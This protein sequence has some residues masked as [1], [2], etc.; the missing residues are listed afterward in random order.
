MIQLC[1]DHFFICVWPP[2]RWQRQGINPQ[3]TVSNV[4]NISCSMH[5]VMTRQLKVHN[6]VTTC[7]YVSRRYSNT[8]KSKGAHRMPL[9]TR[10][11]QGRWQMRNW[12]MTDNIAVYRAGK[13]ESTGRKVLPSIVAYRPFPSFLRPCYLVHH[14][15]S[16]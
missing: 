7:V 2:L 13:S 8:E 4:L 11:I 9:G 5:I 16:N 6:N 1:R 14:F 3:I 12:K 10:L 15:S